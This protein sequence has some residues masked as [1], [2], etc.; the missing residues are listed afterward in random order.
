MKL[1]RDLCAVHAPAGEEEAMRDFLIA[2][3]QKHQKNWKVQP[4]LLYG[5][6]WQNCLVLV[7]GKPRTLMLAHM[8][9]IGFTVRYENQLVPIGGPEAENGFRL[10]GED[11]NGEID[12][13][14]QVSK[15]GHAT[16]HFGRPID[17][18][19]S[20]TFK[21]DF[22]ETR[23]FVQCC[24]MDNRLGI[25]NALQVAETMENGMIAFTCWEEHGGGA[26][27]YVLRRAWE[28]YQIRKCL[29]SDI[30]WVTD[31]V[32]HGKGVVISMR[33]HNIPRRSYVNRIIALAEEHQVPYQLEVEASGSSDGREVQLSPYPMDWCFVGA[34]EDHVHSPDEKVHKYD[35]QSMIALYKVLMAEL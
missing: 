15:E 31:G 4:T 28:D 10:V 34:P 21:P 35:I 2:Y 18:G 7:F 22:R 33:D 26:V 27:P 24:Y 6:D 16:Y 32:H 13:E 29:V 9:S 23:D 30:T 8:D 3:I 25:Y 17:R 14:L 12:C 19:T 5:D 20:L 1:L 11:S